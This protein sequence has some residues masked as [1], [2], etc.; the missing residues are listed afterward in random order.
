MRLNFLIL[1]STLGTIEALKG[2]SEYP[3]M[4]EVIKKKHPYHLKYWLVT[5]MI[6]ANITGVSLPICSS[7]LE[8]HYGN[9]MCC[10][11]IV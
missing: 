4:L 11:L 6:L 8:L 9:V 10:M 1:K 3:K 7:Y 5:Q 2:G